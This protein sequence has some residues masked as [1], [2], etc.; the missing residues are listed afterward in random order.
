M[1]VVSHL[2]LNP[3]TIFYYEEEDVLVWKEFLEQEI[4]TKVIPPTFQRLPS[5]RDYE[6]T[7]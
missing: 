7:R 3:L 5:P 1:D 2:K 6:A 4:I